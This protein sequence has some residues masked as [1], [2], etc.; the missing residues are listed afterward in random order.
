MAPMTRWGATSH[1]RSSVAFDQA[2]TCATCRCLRTQSACCCAPG[3]ALALLGA[4]EDELKGCHFDLDTLWGSAADSA[5]DRL[6]AATNLHRQLDILESLLLARL[7]AIHGMH[8]A[9]AAALGTITAGAGIAA[10]TSASG[11]SH[12]HFAAL[13]RRA[14][15]LAP[16]TYGRVMRFQSALRSVALRNES[17]LAALALEAGYCDQSHFNRDFRLFTGVTPTMYRKLAPEFAH[18]LALPD[19]SGVDTGGQ[20]SPSQGRPTNLA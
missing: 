7:R 10:A 5:L 15:G 12:R 2:I 11:F 6:S 20:V 16:K 19:P 17:D 13:F 3:A 14:T 18:H 8:P 4:R 9:I 1:V